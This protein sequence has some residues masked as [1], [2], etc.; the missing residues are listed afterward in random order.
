MD[1][2]RRVGSFK[3][4]NESGKEYIIDIDEDVG[5]GC[6]EMSTGG[7]PVRRIGTN[8]LMV[9]AGDYEILTTKELLFFAMVIE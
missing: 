9:M 2:R 3:A 7:D 1:D 8:T 4:K 5:T 6:K